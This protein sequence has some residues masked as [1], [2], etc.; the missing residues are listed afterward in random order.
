M[1]MP[2]RTLPPGAAALARALAGALQDGEGRPRPLGDP[3]EPDV[4]RT[5]V[6]LSAGLADDD[7]EGAITAAMVALK[8]D[9]AARQAM[10]VAGLMPDQPVQA[11]LI[12]GYVRMFRRIKALKASGGL[13]DATIMAEA[14]RDMRALNSRLAE[15]L[16]ALRDQQA[17]LSRANRA[18]VERERRQARTSLDLSRARDELA[19]LRS[20]LAQAE[21]ERDEARQ[22]L[23][24]VR[25]ERDA[26]RRE[27]N[28]SRAGVEDLK[29][30]YLEKFALALHDLNRAREALLN[31]PASSL[32]ALKASV[33]QGYYMILEDMNAGDAA[34]KLMASIVTDGF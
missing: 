30:K 19:S 18:Q 23:T 28:R 26:V 16:G 34:R 21:S 6:A 25:E 12:A 20:A 13:D 24:A 8:A 2:D 1:A 11:G 3:R 15:A 10:E 31:D 4:I 9:A 29:A 27:L 33:A 22:A 14:K 7:L 32:P 17:R 5:W